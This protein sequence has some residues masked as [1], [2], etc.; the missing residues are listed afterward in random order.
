MCNSDMSLQIP[1]TCMYLHPGDKVK[2]HRFDSILWIVSYG[3]FTFDGNRGIC[4]WYLTN[5]ETGKIKPIM[6]TDLR[7][8]YLID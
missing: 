2:L 8:I 4:G 3:W 7:D 6:K 1:E 5:F